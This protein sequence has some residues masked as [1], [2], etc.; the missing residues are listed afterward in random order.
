MSTNLSTIK[1][2]T[3]RP[4]LIG[5]AVAGAAL[6]AAFL[7]VRAKSAQA[8][9]RHPPGGKFI[10]VDGV[11]L[12]Y[13]EQGTGPAIVL[14]HG[15][16]VMADDFR[17][18]GLFDRLAQTH[19]VIAFDRPGF[20]YSER[21]ADT[22]WT[23][24]AQ[25]RLLHLALRQLGVDQPIVVGHS[26][27]TL[28]TVAL[29]L[30]YPGQVRAIALLG[31]YYYPSL[32]IDAFLNALA[33][34]PVVGTL[35]RHTAA[36]LLGRLLWPAMAKQVF[37]PV[38]VPARFGQLPPWLALRPSQLQAAAAENGLMVP[39]AWRLKKR[40]R[41][42]TLPVALVAGV[43]DKVIDP[44]KNTARLH[45]ALPVSSMIMPEGAGHMVHYN[46]VDDIA[47]AISRL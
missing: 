41:H 44:E 12:H 37:A 32:R 26:W 18:S 34:V 3:S 39:A 22:T 36:P 17:L 25:A 19:R 14:L 33:A 6:A 27:G 2:A 47:A 21:P 38:P 40:Y 11:R 23:P 1:R 31:G 8:E 5:A 46:K 35:W 9:R 7:V 42:L 4:I 28:V 16:G 20:G 30:D 43:D 29:A 13:L 15:N 24:E 45:N 10:D